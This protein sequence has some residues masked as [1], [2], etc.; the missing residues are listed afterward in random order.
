[1]SSGWRISAGVQGGTASQDL[2]GLL[3]VTDDE[4]WRT[5]TTRSNNRMVGVFGGVSHYAA[6]SEVMGLRLSGTLG[7]MHNR[8][9]YDYVNVLNPTD[10]PPSGR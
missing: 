4:L 8:F 9:E 2:T 3:R 1:M 5:L 7:V 6:L 10:L